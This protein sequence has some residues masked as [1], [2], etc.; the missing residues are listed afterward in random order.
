MSRKPVA[1][2]LPILLL[3]FL[4]VGCSTLHRNLTRAE[5]LEK[6]GRPADALKIYESVLAGIPVSRGRLRAE[7]YFREGDCLIRLDRTADAFSAFQKAA[8]SDPMHLGA[9][10][11]LG[12]FFLSAGA[13]D[14]AREQAEAVLSQGGNSE[15]LALWGAALAASGQ[16]EKAK[17]AF[18]R[19]LQMDPARMSVSLALADLYNRDDQN[20]EARSVLGA[21]EAANPKSAAP[22]LSEARLHEQQGQIGEAERCYRHAV[23]VEDT[24]ET[25]LRLAQFLQRTTRI[26][27]AEQ[28][29]RRVDAQRPAQP[30]AL[31]DFQLLAGR[32]TSALDSY[33]AAL[34]SKLAEAHAKGQPA[35]TVSVTQRAL[36][37]TR[38]VEAGLDLAANKPETE[39]EPAIQRARAHLDRN[40]IDLDQATIAILETE[41]S[42]AEFDLPRAD[43]GAARALA[44]A[45][46][47]AAAHYVLGMVKLRQGDDAGARSEWLAS[48]ESDDGFV[49][50]RLALA[51]QSLRNHDTAGAEGYVIGVVRDE[52]G[53]IRAMNLFARVLLAQKRYASA[54]LIARRAQAIDG[55]SVEPHLVLGQ[56]AL[57][58]ERVAEALIQFEQAV[59]LDAHSKE[60]M[61]GLTEVYRTGTVTRPM[62]AKMETVASADPPSPAL[63]E[64]AGRLYA[65][66]GWLADGRRCLEQAL[67]MD[68]KRTSAATALAK[69]FAAT[70][71]LAAA[72]DSASRT[73]GNSAALLAGVR[74]QERN[75]LRAAID[76]YEKAV[77]GGDHSG[78]AANNLAWLYAQQGTNLDR[79]LALAETAR[80]MAPENPAVLDTVGVVRLRLHKYSDAIQA[81]ESARR[82]AEMGT[83]DPKL[84]AQI[85]QHLAEAYLRAGKTTA[86]ESLRVEG[87][88]RR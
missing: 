59:L 60:A 85:N 79:A 43:A 73:G 54:A 27:E 75:D 51:E 56:I 19:V 28:V 64:I 11:R 25:N 33:E 70:G 34:S 26:T 2:L 50:A 29:L 65:E 81:L 49:P 30:T 72:A 38:L 48:L 83:A 37:A 68:P 52:P 44:L 32:T 45:P 20:D 86:A 46:Q 13:A 6:A 1:F 8:K 47:S 16:K 55:A 42:L 87:D 62:L 4:G 61:E 10:L 82:L 78:V 9:K 88:V 67:R 80:S 41:I 12:E 15:A 53:N 39:R 71:N 69:A 31:P 36:L 77:R 22:W 35:Q 74:A 7:L 18:R 76:N 3:A 63:M 21:A 14:R 58:Q 40:R 23:I 57:E 24:P 5:E 66:H 84:M 17:D